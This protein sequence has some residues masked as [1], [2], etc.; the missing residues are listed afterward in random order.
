VITFRREFANRW[1]HDLKNHVSPVRFWPSAPKLFFSGS[2]LTDL[3]SDGASTRKHRYTM[4][5]EFDAEL[6]R[7]TLLERNRS[8]ALAIDSRSD[9]HDSGQT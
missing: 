2:L 9:A 3:L 6:T 4:F 8:L 7:T 1:E 5:E